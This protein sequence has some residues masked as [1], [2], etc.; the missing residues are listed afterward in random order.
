MILVL[1]GSSSCGKNTIIKELMNLDG[2]LKYINTFTSR[3]KR[4]GETDGNPYFFISKAEFQEK[5]KNGDFFEHELIHN[6]F[7]GVEKNLCKDL[8]KENKHLLKD[9]GVIGTFNLKEQLKDCFVETVYFYVPKHELKK[10]LKKR[11]DSKQQIKLRLKRFKFEKAN[12]KKYNFVIN[13]KNKQDTIKILQKIL[14]NN[15][16]SKYFIKTTKKLNKVDF[17]KLQIYCDN[18]INNKEYNPIKLYFNGEDFFVKR[19]FEKYLASLISGKNLAKRVKL[20]YEKP[21]NLVSSEE[22]LNLASKFEL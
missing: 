9:M 13:N 7:Y 3:D 6:N 2:E 8:L 4:A 16:N 15:S 17:K 1:S 12:M 21:K 14:Q 18:M 11:G 19:N 22:I 10:R 5:I 20:T